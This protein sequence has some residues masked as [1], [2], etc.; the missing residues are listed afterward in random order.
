MAVE[1]ELD[2]WESARLFAL[3]NTALADGY[4]ASWAVKYDDLF[5]RPVTAIPEAATDGNRATTPDP[6][7]TPLDTTPPIPDHDSAHAVQGAA[8]ATVMA[9]FFG[10]DRVAFSTCSLTLPEGQQCDDPAPT[11]RDYTRFSQAAQENADSRVWV[12]YHFRH[13]S[14]V[15]LRHGRQ[16]AK[17]VMS[18][19]LKKAPGGLH[20]D[21]REDD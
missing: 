3:L 17:L 12:G 20:R 5:W 1:R 14:E 4:I 7:W 2:P 6:T 13:A 8:A 9:K 19:L 21:C 16:V 10:T 18:G 11:Q 15:G